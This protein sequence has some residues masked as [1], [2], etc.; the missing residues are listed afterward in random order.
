MKTPVISSS[1]QTNFNG[2]SIGKVKK[3][4]LA[5]AAIVPLMALAPINSS[6]KNNNDSFEKTPI[7]KID[8]QKKADTSSGFVVVALISAIATYLCTGNNY[9]K[10]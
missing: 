9:K 7:V 4:G 5:C 2:I 6:A 10:Q 1:N 3:T 8:A